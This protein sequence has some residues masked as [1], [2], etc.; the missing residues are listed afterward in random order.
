MSENKKYI[1]KEPQL[2]IIKIEKKE[3]FNIYN[4]LTDEDLDRIL[5]GYVEYCKRKN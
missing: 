5:I 2:E 3:K 1:I 4:Y